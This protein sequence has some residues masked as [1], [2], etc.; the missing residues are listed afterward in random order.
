MEASTHPIP[1]SMEDFALKKSGSDCEVC[2]YT[3]IY[4]ALCHALI[5]YVHSTFLGILR[6]CMQLGVHGH[7]ILD[8]TCHKSLDMT[9]KCIANVVIRTPTA[10]NLPITLTIAHCN[11]QSEDAIS[12]IFLKK[13]LNFVMADNAHAN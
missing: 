5:I 8:T 7:P 10:K 13:N 11:I 6:I 2:R 4:I 1:F 3:P 9:Y 12:K